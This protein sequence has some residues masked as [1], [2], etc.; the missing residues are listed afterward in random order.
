M[1]DNK[2]HRD[3][4]GAWRA[5]SSIGGLEP[6]GRDADL[7]EQLTRRLNPDAPSIEAALEH[8]SVAQLLSAL[9][10]TIQPFAGMFRDIL[11][12]F[13]NANARIGQSQLK[14]S[15]GDEL[16]ELSHFEQFLESWSRIDFDIDVPALDRRNAFA[17]NSVRLDTGGA[18]YLRGGQIGDDQI[19]LGKED[20]DGWFQAYSEGNYL[21][22]PHSLSPEFQPPGLDDA[23]RVVMAALHVLRQ[24]GLTRDELLAEHQ[25]RKYHCD[26]TDAFHPW[27]IAQSETDYWLRSQVQYLGNLLEEPLEVRAKFGKAVDAKFSKFGRRMFSTTVDGKA[28][29]RILSLPVW[30]RRYEFY[31]VWVGTQILDALD[32]HEIVI[33]HDKGALRFAFAE[34]RLADINS[35]RPPLGLYS[36]RR[37]SLSNPVGKSRKKSVQPDY[38]LWTSA[39]G[40]GS[41]VLVVEVKHYKRESSS[42]FGAALFDYSRA[43]PKATVVL[44]NYGPASIDY[45]SIWS[46]DKER[47]IALGHFSPDMPAVRAQFRDLVREMVGEPVR[48]VHVLPESFTISVF[49]IDVSQSMTSLLNSE[50][51]WTTI[52]AK[53]FEVCEFVLVDRQ[54]RARVTRDGLRNWLRSEPLGSSTSLFETV[55]NLVQEREDVILLTDADGAASVFDLR[56]VPVEFEGMPAEANVL[57][58]RK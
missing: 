36:E 14:L 9:L 3:S 19:V 27:T 44:V 7:V 41:C 34:A 10:A 24:R 42:N 58:F 49:A 51:F 43:H 30:K 4:L 20:I 48:R 55:Y 26:D 47:C 32:D 56:G 31:G 18:D 23:A 11:A 37:S 39:A 6:G 25:A 38:G 5:L 57:K 45:S 2:V 50:W 12:F 40:G 29:E 53:R 17:L 54:L 46:F 21:P 15:V 52:S 35:S 22:L 16:A 1:S 8:V 33:N 28:L 13:K